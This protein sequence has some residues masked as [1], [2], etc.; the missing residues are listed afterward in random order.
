MTTPVPE[1]CCNQ[2]DAVLSLR[3]SIARHLP[4]RDRAVPHGGE[5]S[6][7]LVRQRIGVGE[8]LEK[9]AACSCI[10]A[11]SMIGT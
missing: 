4:E 6:S 9:L 11:A 5:R 2:S 1:R 8:L 7:L 10:E 3:V